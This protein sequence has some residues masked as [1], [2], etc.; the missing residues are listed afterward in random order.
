MICVCEICK[1]RLHLVTFEMKKHARCIVDAL[2]RYKEHRLVQRHNTFTL[3]HHH[4]KCLQVMMMAGH[5]PWLLNTFGSFSAPPSPDTPYMKVLQGSHVW[6]ESRVFPDPETAL[7]SFE[8]SHTAIRLC[9]CWA[10]KCN[11]LL[12]LFLSFS[13]YLFIFY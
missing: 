5:G 10:W 3:K 4:L 9:F 6:L 11:S 2:V 1:L 8:M 13:I 7:C 12:L